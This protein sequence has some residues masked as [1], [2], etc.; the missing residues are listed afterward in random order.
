MLSDRDDIIVITDEA[1]RSQYDVLAMNMRDALPNAAFLA[2]T[3]TPLIVGEE[4]TRQVFGEYVSVYSYKQ[5]NEDGSTV[6]LY[7]ENRIPEMELTNQQLHEDMDRL[8]EEAELDD[9][10][11]AKLARE[12]AHEY[13]LVTRDDRL[14]KVAGDIVDHFCSRGYLGKAMV[15]SIDKLTTVRMYDKVQRHWQRALAEQRRRLAAAPPEEQEDIQA[16]IAFMQGT[17]MAVVI[18]QEQG[19]VQKYK[20]KGLDIYAHRK[21][22]VT[23]ALDEKF[24]DPDDPFR[25][26]FVCAMWRTGFD[27]PACS[28]IYLDRPMRNH[29]LMQTIAR[30]NRVFGE[31]NNGLIVDYIG[32]FRDLQKAL[33]I[34]GS[35]VAGGLGP[36][37]RPIESKD[38]LVEH[39][40][41]AIEGAEDFCAERGVDLRPIVDADIFQR[42]ALMDDAVEQVIVN[43]DLKDQYLALAARA[44][45]LFKAVLPDRRAGDFGP[46][47]HVLVVLADKIRS[48]APPVDISE[49]MGQ[50]DDLLDRSVS[51]RGYVIR[52]TSKRYDLS[53][54][55]FDALR[56]QFKKGRKRTEVEKLRG[57]ISV[58]LQ[59]MVRLNPSRIDY[60]EAFQRLI[61]E[62]NAG[63]RNVE[64]IYEAL[65]RFTQ[66]LN[67]EEQRSVAEGLTEEELA[68]FD[69]LTRPGP[70]LSAREKREVKRIARELLTT[71]KEQKLTLDWRKR[72]Q[73]RAAVQVAIEDLVWT[74]PEGC[75]TDEMCG[76]K[77][78]AIYQHIYDNY[79]GAGQS[80]YAQAA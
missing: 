8:L 22:M 33:A 14:E 5:S 70:K 71:L 60:L 46:K 12:F 16:K 79:W 34:Y 55:D 65:I 35:G 53:Q 17:D 54:V 67:E 11:E 40:R 72:Q 21:R 63:S 50:V 28:T 49:V 24:K 29:T 20:E 36:G 42:V 51:A 48:L 6:P 1:H 9:E 10:Q 80:V 25:L 61:D 23:E 59:R 13:H 64:E 15:V 44:D 7:Y 2:F 18:S 32:I 3:A 58:K 78:V 76:E 74:L 69:I 43:D 56:E 68:V 19:E 52:E 45:R 75:Y 4:R 47:R 30:A 39:L 57:T 37:E 77:S 26:V 31:K 66:S 41:A 62:Y 38:E 27:A 73:S